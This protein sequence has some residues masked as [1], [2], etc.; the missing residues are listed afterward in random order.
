MKKMKIKSILPVGKSDVYDISVDKYENYILSNGVITHNSGLKYAA[1]S[2]AMLTK[3]KD[4][5]DNKEIIGNIIKV[6]MFKSRFTKEGKVAE[7]KLSFDKGLDRYYG[8]LEL[9]EKY[10]IFK[11]VSTRYELPNGTKVFASAI[12]NDPEKYYTEEILRAIDEAA[13]KE[14]QYGQSEKSEI[15][16]DENENCV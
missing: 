5:D 2:I 13:K 16:H 11:K 15:E 9:A 6:S 10:E 1:S 8:L 3:K 12:N 7:V 4:R 14:F